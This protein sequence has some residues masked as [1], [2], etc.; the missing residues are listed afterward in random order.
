MANTKTTKNSTTEPTGKIIKKSFIEEKDASALKMA[1]EAGL[2]MKSLK[3]SRGHD[4]DGYLSANLYV[5]NK[6]AGSF[7]EDTHG[8]GYMFEGDEAF[9]EIATKLLETNGTYYCDLFKKERLVS[10]D[11]LI[12]LMALDKGYRKT[13]KN[14]TLILATKGENGAIIEMTSASPWNKNY[15]G[16]EK[17][18]IRD[19]FTHYEIV[20]DR[21]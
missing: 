5:N 14:K 10:Y 18:L 7:Y 11:T 20:N 13:A 21:F 3:Y 15:S 8:G 17:L 2:D 6:K 9:K 4:G 16:F 12:Y 19:G 1:Y